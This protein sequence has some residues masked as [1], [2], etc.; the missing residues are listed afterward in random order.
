MI[1]EFYEEFHDIVR[2]SSRVAYVHYEERHSYAEMYDYMRRLNKILADRKNQRIAIFSA[3]SFHNYSALFGVILSNNTWIPINPDLPENRNVEMLELTR[4]EV[5][6][7]DRELPPQISASAE[8]MRAKVVNLQ[9]ID[10]M[11]PGPEFDI[12][13]FDKDDLS[14]IYFTS[15]STGTPK[16]VPLTH[17]NYILN[18]RNALRITKL[19][20]GEVF[21]DYHDLG[22]VISIP[23]LFACIMSEGAFA[24]AVQKKDMM[25]PTN[26]MRA[27]GVTVLISVPSTMARIRQLQPDGVEND[28]LKL[29]IMCGEPLH[30]D[31][32]EYILSELGVDQVFDFYGSTEVAPWT[33]C[34]ECSLDD[35]EK[36]QAFGVVPIGKPTAGN[37]ARIGEDDELW[38]SGR[39]ITPGYL[40]GV[41]SDAFVELEGERWYRT[42]DKVI[43]HD[44]HYLCKGRL[45]SQVKIGGHRIELMDTEA[46]LR[47][48][49]GVHMAICFVEGEGAQKSIV[50]ALHASRDVW[51]NEVRVHLK[52]KLPGYMIPRKSF[53]IN[54][55][56]LNKSGKIDRL[57]IRAQYEDALS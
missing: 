56:P 49:E 25:L 2:Q 31:I 11:T 57:A 46:H 50:A 9:E 53:V 12:S 42:G 32:L 45:D 35:L 10:K 36:F 39:Q 4:P 33:F 48:L 8:A 41:G 21:A 52:D 40:G 28:K 26:N 24:P 18:V 17:E 7:T 44:G 38:V 19:G 13:G 15:G 37:M 14:M 27:N 20:R 29:V 43:V 30:L 6:L 16:G 22:F 23:I 55:L 47:S 34:H 54:E 51:L 5:I 3:K 1:K